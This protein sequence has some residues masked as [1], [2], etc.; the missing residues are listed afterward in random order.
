MND[1]YII[2]VDAN[3]EF[4]LCSIKGCNCKGNYIIDNKRYCNKHYHHIKKFGEV[5]RTIYDKNEIIKHEDYAE[6]IVRDKY[7]NIKGITKIDLDDVDKCSKFKC[8]MYSS[9]Y[10]YLNVNKTKRYRLHRFILGIFTSSKDILVDHIDRNPA[11]NRKCNLRVCN[12]LINNNNKTYTYENRKCNSRNV[13][14][15]KR[16][17]KYYSDFRYNSKKYFC[18][19]FDTEEEAYNAYISKRNLVINN[20]KLKIVL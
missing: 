19:Y 18:G 1:N 17:N 9:G 4:R 13:K 10:F 8:G 7:N 12:Y 20:I 11:N 14:Y 6:I 3:A 5:Q 15:D 16:R 2:K